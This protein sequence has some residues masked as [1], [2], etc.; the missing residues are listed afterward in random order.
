MKNVPYLT[1]FPRSGSHY[2]DEL[3]YKETGVYIEKSHSITSV[4][5][6][7]NNKQ[8]SLI[9]IARD[10]KDSIISYIANAKNNRLK[11]PM[12]W[13]YEQVRINQV[14]TEYITM[15]YFLYNHAD[16]VID[17]QDLVS[18]P[19]ATIKKILR[20]LEIDEKDHKPFDTSV[21]NYAK[22]YIPSSKSL[23]SYDNTILDRFNINLCYFHYNKILEKKILI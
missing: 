3:F 8:K 4:F 21:H 2:F 19:D 13:Y 22:E 17:F 7:N 20:V 18:F 11:E 10:P 14:L 23:S 9:T 12:P 6:K 15:Y 5:D 16:Y 1:T